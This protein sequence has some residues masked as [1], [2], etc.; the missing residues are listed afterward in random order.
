M[1]GASRSSTLVIGLFEMSSKVTELT[2]LPVCLIA[3]LIK[4]HD[5]NLRNAFC[6]LKSL[7]PCARPNIA[8]FAQ[9]IV[10]EKFY[11]TTTSVEIVEIVKNGKTISVPDFYEAMFPDLYK[12]E[13]NK[14][15]NKSHISRI[16]LQDS[17]KNYINR[18]RNYQEMHKDIQNLKDKS[19]S[20]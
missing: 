9:L 12:A 1:A 14:Q 10:Y 20:V 19:N 16:Q 8:F 7:R 11:R 15:L 13:V 17:N 5:M 3:Y 18:N 2:S 4:Y 6:Y